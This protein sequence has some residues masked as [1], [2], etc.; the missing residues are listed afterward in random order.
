MPPQLCIS[1]SPDLNP[2]DYCMW[3]IVQAKVY[4][5]RITDVDELKLPLRMEWAKLDQVVT[6]P[7]IRQ[8]RRRLSA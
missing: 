6:A 4:K 8:W 5:R 7:A 2:V 1:N 3:E